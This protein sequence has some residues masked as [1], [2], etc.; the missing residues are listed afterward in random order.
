MAEFL[1]VC[2]DV[3]RCG[4]FDP[5]SLWELDEKNAKDLVTVFQLIAR[6]RHYPDTL[7]Y[8]P[9]IDQVLHVWEPDFKSE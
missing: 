3:E 6:C 2:W 5:A 4:E 7:G 1:L 8:G 9:A